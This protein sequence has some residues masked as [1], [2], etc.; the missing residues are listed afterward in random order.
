MNRLW[1]PWR[2]AY[3]QPKRPPQKGC[4]FCRLIQAPSRKDRS[5]QILK[6]TTHSFAILN[7]YPYNNG[8]VMIVHCRHAASLHQLKDEEKLD[9]LSLFD[10]VMQALKKRL[11]PQG[12]NA[13]INM[14]KVAGAGIPGH[15]HLHLVPRWKGDS[16]FMPV[17]G[18]TKV[19]SQSLKQVYE[20]ITPLL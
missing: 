7:L 15:I 14:G 8:H 2:Q 12:F 3:I 11:K 19:I 9:L 10:S 5:H 18:E 6:R 16:N 17:V 1:A 20:L 4:L 13:G